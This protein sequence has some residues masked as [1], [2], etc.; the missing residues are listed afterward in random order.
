MEMAPVTIATIPKT[1]HERRAARVSSSSWRSCA[2]WL[3]SGISTSVIGCELEAER[4]GAFEID[5]AGSL[6][7]LDLEVRTQVR[8]P[9]LELHESHESHRMAERNRRCDVVNGRTWD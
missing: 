1:T 7:E 8:A 2:R 5:M 4:A 3:L 6:G 9:S